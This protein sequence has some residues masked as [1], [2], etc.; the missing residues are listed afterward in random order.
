MRVVF[1]GTPEPAAVA[2]DALLASRHE[3]AA[4]VTQP[5]RPRGRS[6]TPQPSP[7]KVRALEAGLPVL[8]P[9]SP[10]DEGFAGTL[11]GF[12]PQV[13]AV[14]A[15]GHILPPEVLA[16]PLRGTV[17]VHF[18][19]LPAYRGA[20]PVQRAIMAGETETGVTTFLLE[21]TVDTGPMLVQIRERI[22][23]DDSTGSLL[24]RLAP[25]G[26]RAL[27][28]TL[29]GLEAG[30][31]EPVEQDPAL[32]SPAPKIKPEEGTIDW[33]RPALE[34]ADLVRALAPSP[35][36]HS[37]FREKRIKLWRA[38]PIDG[39]AAEPGAVVDAGKDRLVV[40]TGDGLLEVQELQQEGA[41]RLEAS[42]F[43]RGH[44][45]RAGETFGSL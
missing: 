38:R 43:V 32:A 39:A 27:V 8:Q 44:R 22:D 9:S 30:T 15:Y 11:A 23:P 28:D 12:R 18:S 7:V 33:R 37:T 13:C 2:L 1:F 6:G 16:V 29:D 10:R 36:A 35:G 40:A 24:E 5:D 31:L 45:P 41:K 20:A 26:A 17:N 42:A 19:L 34:I 3:V 25:I 21:P 14:V 4:A